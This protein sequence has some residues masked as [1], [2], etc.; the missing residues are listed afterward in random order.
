MAERKPSPARRRKARPKTIKPV[1]FVPVEI[2]FKPQIEVRALKD[3]NGWV[4]D[5]RDRVKFHIGHGRIGYIDEDTA[6]EWQVKGYVEVLGG[7]LKPVS[8]DEAAE[9]L[10]TVTTIG[11]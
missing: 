5:R 11:L 9:Y 1:T 10:S 2:A 6:R 3:V 4:G 8:E 7:D